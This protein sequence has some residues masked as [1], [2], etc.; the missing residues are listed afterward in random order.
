MLVV[1]SAGH[2]PTVLMGLQLRPLR[3]HSPFEVPPQLYH[4]PSCQSHNTDL[5]ASCPCLGEPFHEPACQLA[6][7][8]VTHPAPGRFYRDGAYVAVSGLADSRFES[9]LSCGVGVSPIKEATSR[10]FRNFRQPNSSRTITH[11]LS[12]PMPWSFLSCSIFSRSGASAC[13]SSLRRVASN[14]RI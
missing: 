9:P 6:S 13:L 1:S 2:L 7:G 8:L 5:S 3:H 12:G 11:E 4:Q 14:S 10:R